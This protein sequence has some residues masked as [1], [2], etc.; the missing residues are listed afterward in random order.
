M[1]QIDRTTFG[2]GPM[3]KMRK[4][5]H[6]AEFVE[7][8]EDLEK[9]FPRYSL[10]PQCNRE[11]GVRFR[12]LFGRT[13]ASKTVNFALSSWAWTAASSLDQWRS[14]DSVLFEAG[15]HRLYLEAQYPEFWTRLEIEALIAVL[16]KHHINAKA[17]GWGSTIK[18]GL[19]RHNELQ[20]ATINP[21]PVYS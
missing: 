3:L 6:R 17:R 2:Y 16:G 14:D 19:K 4:A 8:L 10:E 1:K 7:L 13:E 21:E 12:P 5:L 18:K 20:K 11:G 15:D 9:A